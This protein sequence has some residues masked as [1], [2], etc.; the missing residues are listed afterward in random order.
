MD[1]VSV[2]ASTRAALNGAEGSAQVTALK[3]AADSEKAVVAV[4]EQAVEASKAAPP[5]GQG[6]HVDKLA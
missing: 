2:S 6:Q 3:I 5:A 1:A 4:V